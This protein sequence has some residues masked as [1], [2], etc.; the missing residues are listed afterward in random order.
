MQWIDAGDLPELGDFRHYSRDLYGYG[1]WD[2]QR[3][4]GYCSG[5]AYGYGELGRVGSRK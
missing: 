1:G 5:D 3:L 2:Q 4:D